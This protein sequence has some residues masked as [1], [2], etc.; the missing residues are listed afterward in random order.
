MNHQ[1]QQW[2]LLVMVV[3]VMVAVFLVEGA[4]CTAPACKTCPS[5]A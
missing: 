3:M 5:Q 1:Q 2:L 4:A